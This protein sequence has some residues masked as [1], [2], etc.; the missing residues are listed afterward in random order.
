MT[1]DADRI[2]QWTTALHEAGRKHEQIP[3]PSKTYGELSVHDAYEV[4]AR[5]AARRIADGERQVG[6][7]VGATSFAI[8]EQFKD[9][10]D[11]PSYGAILSGTTWSDP[12]FIDSSLFFVLTSRTTASNESPV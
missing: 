7:K 4:Q 1:T 2:E 11:G 8:L 6:W 3:G 9:Q 5:V 12:E 10:I